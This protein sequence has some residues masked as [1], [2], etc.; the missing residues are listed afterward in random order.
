MRWKRREAYS[1]EK[2]GFRTVGPQ[3]QMHYMFRST[4]DGW[5]NMAGGEGLGQEVRKTGP[6]YTS[7]LFLFLF[8]IIGN[9]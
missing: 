6:D 4:L 7:V 1:G 3:M 8:L 2:I 9:W 5:T